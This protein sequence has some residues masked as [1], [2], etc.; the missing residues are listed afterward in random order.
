V[1]GRQLV[2]GNLVGTRFNV[3]GHEFAVVLGIEVGPH[4]LFVNKVATTREF[5]FAIAAFD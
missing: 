2:G 5:F 1:A 4:L 3:N